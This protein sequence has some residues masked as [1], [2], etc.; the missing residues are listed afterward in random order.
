ML[1]PAPDTL[2]IVGAI[3]QLEISIEQRPDDLARARP[4]LTL[5]G[6]RLAACALQIVCQ[7]IEQCD[8][9]RQIKPGYHLLRLIAKVEPGI[10]VLVRPLRCLFADSSQEGDDRGQFNR[11]P[12]Y[13][14]A[15]NCDTQ[16]SGVAFSHQ[17]VGQRSVVVGF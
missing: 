6:S 12:E 11:F 8:C 10:A 2:R 3:G 1:R 5:V 15:F 17:R 4:A 13:F 14:N 9:G 16:R 7:I